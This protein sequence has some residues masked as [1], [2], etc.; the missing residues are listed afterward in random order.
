MR[1]LLLPL[2][3]LLLPACGPGADPALSVDCAERAPGT[4]VVGTGQ[5]SFEAIG[6]SGVEVQEGPQGGYH[7]WIGLRCQNLGPRVTAKFGVRDL[8]TGQDL[9]FTGLQQ[10]VELVYDEAA[11]ADEIAGIYGYLADTPPGGD[12]P[13]PTDL[14]GRKIELWAEVI[15]QCGEPV[16][17]KTD[18]VVKGYNRL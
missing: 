15:D 5:E 14:Q 12:P 18:T 7:I 16:T 11:H 4:V 10:S 1:L 3:A 17:A 2:A 9:S 13:G 6:D 8:P